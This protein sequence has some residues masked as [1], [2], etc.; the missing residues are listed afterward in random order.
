MNQMNRREL[1][2]A[3]SAFAMIGSLS[4]EAQ[5]GASSEGAPR[6]LH[7]EL[8]AYD[9]LPVRTAPNGMTTRAVMRGTLAT[10]EYIEVH[11]T[12][13]PAG[14]MPHPPHRHTHSELLLIREGELQVDSDGQRGLVHPG[15]VVFTASAVLHSLKNVGQGPASYFVVAVGVQK[16]LS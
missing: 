5:S 11:E 6:L 14:E 12:M 16:A 1:G 15:D 7:S 9:K 8:F 4:A 10:G 3:L 13:L 2:V